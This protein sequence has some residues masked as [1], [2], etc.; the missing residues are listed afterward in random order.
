M[1]G[2]FLVAAGRA[3]E[4]PAKLNPEPQAATY[5]NSQAWCFPSRLCIG[6]A[7]PFDHFMRPGSSR[8]EGTLKVDA[9]GAQAGLLA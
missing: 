7:F 2:N 5:I 8:Y 1:F 3:S 6:G 4:R 9:Y